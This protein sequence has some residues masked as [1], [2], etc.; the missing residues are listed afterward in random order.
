MAIGSWDPDSAAASSAITI[1]PAVLAQFADYSRN[2]QLKQ[3]EALIDAEHIQIYAGLM[4]L[5]QEQWLAAAEQ[6]NDDEILQLIRFFAVA[7]NLPG[8]EAGAKSPVIA[9]AKTLRSR[10]Q[11]LERA[12]LVWLREVNDNRFLP[13]GPL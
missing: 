7:E 11:R 9:L 12:L 6:L 4:Q 2:H 10:G 3:L 1:D 8:W 5:E 13:Y